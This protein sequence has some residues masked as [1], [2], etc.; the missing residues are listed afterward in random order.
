[1]HFY[2]SQETILWSF[3]T[4]RLIQIYFKTCIVTMTVAAILKISNHKY[5]S[6]HPN[7]HLSDFPLIS[8]Q[9][10][11]TGRKIISPYDSIVNPNT[12][13]IY[14]EFSIYYVILQPLRTA[15]LTLR[16]RVV[17]LCFTPCPFL[18]PETKIRFLSLDRNDRHFFFLLILQNFTWKSL[19]FFV[20]IFH[21]NSFLSLNL[22]SLHGGWYSLW[23][24]VHEQRYRF[25][26]DQIVNW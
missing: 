13:T 1:M 17:G 20:C 14:V 9:H 8:D 12:N 10:I 24:K 11:F 2:T 23:L 5:T 26:D 3:I 15:H 6:T 18:W 4:I 16:V 21:V 7:V 22:R 25:I 19:A